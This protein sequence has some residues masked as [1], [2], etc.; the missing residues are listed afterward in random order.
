MQNNNVTSK[1]I[2]KAFLY[3][4]QCL[5]KH[6]CL[7]LNLNKLN[8]SVDNLF[9]SSFFFLLFIFYIMLVNGI[10]VNSVYE[11]LEAYDTFTLTLDILLVRSMQTCTIIRLYRIFRLLELWEELM[12]WLVYFF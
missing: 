3:S 7:M 4:P 2:Q 11:T 5:N 10:G 8:M 12:F 1:C 6:M 9:L